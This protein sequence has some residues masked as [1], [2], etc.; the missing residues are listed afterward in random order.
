MGAAEEAAGEA[1]VAITNFPVWHE[2]LAVVVVALLSALASERKWLVAF[3]LCSSCC[4]ERVCDGRACVNDRL[5]LEGWTW[6]MDESGPCT[7]VVWDRPLTAFGGL[8][9]HVW[10]H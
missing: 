4:F 1:A 5:V 9:H 2:A 8:D 10:G 3:D 7:R 6:K